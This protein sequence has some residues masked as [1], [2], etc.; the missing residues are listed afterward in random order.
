MTG[1][2]P[3]AATSLGQSSTN[4]NYQ[5]PVTHGTF[6]LS[7][8]GAALLIGDVFPY[9][10]F[11]IDGRAVT[12]SAQRPLSVNNGAFTYTGQSVELDYG[13]GIV[14]DVT[15]F[16]YTGQ[17]VVLDVGFGIGANNGS[18]SLTGQ[19]IDFTKQMNISEE[20]EAITLTCLDA[21]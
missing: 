17:N 3:I 9:G 14:V 4:A 20:T 10:V 7:M 12:L 19:S 16:A 15:T 2:A 6:A 8:R 21:F 5:M 13:F 11:Q 18:F 1:F